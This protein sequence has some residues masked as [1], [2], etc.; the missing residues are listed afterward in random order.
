M[1]NMKSDREGLF[2]KILPLLALIRL[3]IILYLTS[4]TFVYNYYENS[5]ANCNTGWAPCFN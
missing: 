3:G 4:S 2:G 5:Q 1:K